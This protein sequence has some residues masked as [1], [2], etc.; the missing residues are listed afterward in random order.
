MIF[1]TQDY[2][3]TASRGE[4]I[5]ANYAASVHFLKAIQLLRARFSD[6]QDASVMSDVTVTI[7]LALSMHAQ[8]LGQYATAR[9]HMS[10]LRK[11]VDLRGGTTSFRANPKLLHEILRS[12]AADEEEFRS[13]SVSLC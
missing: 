5:R 8:M 12:V 9:E 6:S 13:T 3:A 10:G 4:N 1:S 11:I 7:V 2:F